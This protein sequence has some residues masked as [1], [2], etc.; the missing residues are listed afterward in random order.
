MN[1]RLSQ[2]QKFSVSQG[3]TMET[4][5]GK[6]FDIPPGSLTILPLVIIVIIA[7]ITPF[8][9]GNFVPLARKFTAHETCITHLQRVGVGLVLYAISMSIAGLVEVKRKKLAKDPNGNVGFYTNGLMEFF[10]SEAP[11]GMR[12]L[13][14]AFSWTSMALGYFLNNVLVKIVNCATHMTKTHRWLGG[15]NLNRNHLNLFYWLLAILSMLNFV[16]YL[17]WSRW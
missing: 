2:L 3:L 13:A 11:S 5:M 7:I 8:Y 14:T 9:N 15:N 4:S 17:Y 10:Y 6:N 1:T 12:S 16:N